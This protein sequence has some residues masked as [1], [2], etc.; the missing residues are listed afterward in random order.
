MPPITRRALAR[1][2]LLLPLFALLAL[3]GFGLCAAG[4]LSGGVVERFDKAHTAALYEFASR[5]PAVWS[6]F[7]TVTDAASGQAMFVLL[8]ASV[9]VLFV[10][11][12]PRTAL[13]LVVGLAVIE[14]A[15]SYLK[16]AF[17]RARPFFEGEVYREYSASFPSGHSMRAAFWYGM[18]AFLVARHG[19]RRLRW[20]FVGGCGLLMCLIGLSRMMLGVHY[21]TDV[22]GGFCMGLAVLA[23]CLTAELR[24]EN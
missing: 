4:Y 6:F 18:L 5:R 2:R 22:L 9:S 21:L 17:D 1:P 3:S 11:G 12:R 7:R 23:G 14:Y 24:I 16:L 8:V 13:V 10:I 15:S 20:W 19:P